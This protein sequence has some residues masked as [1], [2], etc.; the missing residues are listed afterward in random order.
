MRIVLTVQL[1]VHCRQ[2]PAGFWVSRGS[3]RVIRRPWCLAC[4]AGLDP[5]GCDIAPFGGSRVRSAVGPAA[6]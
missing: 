4:C 2:R 5:A 3:D 6:R 1:C